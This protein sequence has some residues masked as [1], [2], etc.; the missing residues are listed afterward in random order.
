MLGG[1]RTTVKRERVRMDGKGGSSGM[2]E[3]WRQK[4]VQE[5][6]NSAESGTS[7][8][9]ESRPAR[10]D[11]LA[12]LTLSAVADGIFRPDANKAVADK[13]SVKQSLYPRKGRILISRSNTLELVGA[14]VFVNSDFPNRFLPDLIWQ[15]EPIEQTPVLM[16]WFAYWLQSDAGRLQLK[17]IASGSNASMV[18]I[19]K[20]NF[21]K[22]ELPIPPLEEQRKIADILST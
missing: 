12:I 8:V 16:N 6:I 10:S 14:A 2:P 1:W 21:L 18:K 3:G 20:A 5:F 17:Q 15:L 19:S 9:A 13:S 4:R 22:I 11:E 7:V